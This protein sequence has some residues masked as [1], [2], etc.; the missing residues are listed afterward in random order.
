MEHHMI[1]PSERLSRR[2]FIGGTVASTIAVAGGSL[3]A[4]AADEQ[5]SDRKKTVKD[6]PYN[7]RT[8]K[9]MPTRNL[10]KT[11]F[12]VGILSLGGQATLEIKEKEKESVEIINR[13]I[14]LGVNYID[15]AAGYGDGVS[16]INIGQVLKDRRSEVFQTSKTADRSYD[17]SMRLLEKSLKQLQTDHLDLWQLHNLRRQDEVDKIFANDGALKALL[18]AREEGMVRF[19]GITGHYE[20]LVLKRALDRFEFD[21]ILMA[22]NAADTHYLSFRRYLLPVA[23]K[24]G[25]GIIGMKLATRGRLLSSWTPPPAETQPERLRTMLPGTITMKESLYYNCTLPVSTNIVGVDDV[26]QLEQNVQWVSKFS[27]LSPEEIEEIEYRTLPVV[28]QALYFRR[29]DMGA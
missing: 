3:T 9:A 26:A 29:W 28:R 21:T 5:R 8:H 18:K 14:D 1:D 13:A 27:P 22:V 4:Y 19:L 20:P 24:K 12:H 10:G 15:T 23:Q 16:E 6:L 11:G 7:P 25:I 17:G 2:E